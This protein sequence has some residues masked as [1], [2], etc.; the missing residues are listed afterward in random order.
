MSFYRKFSEVKGYTGDV[1][2]ILVKF[3]VPSS[4]V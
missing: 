1:K 4:E 2:V 3:E